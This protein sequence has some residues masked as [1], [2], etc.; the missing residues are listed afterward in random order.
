MAD[1]TTAMVQMVSLTMNGTEKVIRGSAAIIKIM[2][3]L[4]WQVYLKIKQRTDLLPGERTMMRFA[5]DGKTLQCVSMNKEQ[6]D[7]FKD[8]AIKYN[9]QYHHV[10][11][12]KGK[13]E[14]LVTV[15][16]P[17]S[18]AHKFN[19]LVNDLKLNSVKNVG[20]VQAEDVHPLKTPSMTTALAENIDLEGT[21][22][23]SDLRNN[24]I[25]GGMDPDKADLFVGDLLNSSEF[26]NA[27]DNGTIKNIVAMPIEI[28]NNITPA[29]NISA[30]EITDKASPFLS[31]GISTRNWET[32]RLALEETRNRIYNCLGNGYD[33]TVDSFKLEEVKRLDRCIELG[34]KG[35]LS[36]I[37][38]DEELFRTYE[39]VISATEAEI[40]ESIETKSLK[41]IG[42]EGGHGTTNY[43]E[44]VANP[45]KLGAIETGGPE[46]TPNIP[47]PDSKL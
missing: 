1:E 2:A 10:N 24:L 34:D 18:D 19:R 6:Y 47:T 7:L 4:L 22:N 29:A 44:I 31:E 30:S 36:A 37:E 35:D 16:I 3:R 15:F 11:N 5:L 27:V 43:A 25:K 38:A 14:D 21:L 28:S 46:I 39:S 23:L 13:G 17:E 40:G 32:D 45:T 33:N 26:S 20:T 12:K 42:M 41:V 9:I 8:N